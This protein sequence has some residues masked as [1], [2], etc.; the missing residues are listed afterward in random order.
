MKCKVNF[1]ITYENP[2]INTISKFGNFN[3]SRL[4]QFYIKFYFSLYNDVY[5]MFTMCMIYMNCFTFPGQ[6]N[7]V[8]IRIV[9]EYI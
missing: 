4:V 1:F 9:Y 6:L 3:L 8:L 5:V 7:P 2:I